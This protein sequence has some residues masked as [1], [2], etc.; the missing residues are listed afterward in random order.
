MHLK[1]YFLF[2]VLGRPIDDI[3]VGSQMP[4]RVVVV[5]VVVTIYCN[6]GKVL[7]CIWMFYILIIIRRVSS[8][9][10]QLIASLEELEYREQGI[11]VKVPVNIQPY[12]V[13]ISLKNALSQHQSYPKR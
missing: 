7:C 8:S 5:D 6:N 10:Y 12:V 13:S 2:A 3:G 4:C 9:S 11:S 1:I